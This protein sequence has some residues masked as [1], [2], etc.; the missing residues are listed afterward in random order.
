M[1]LPQLLGLKLSRFCSLRWAVNKR[2]VPAKHHQRQVGL[3]QAE[4][5][6]MGP[7]QNIGTGMH[8]SSHA[9]GLTLAHGCMQT[10]VSH[11]RVSILLR[12]HVCCYADCAGAT[13]AIAA[14][15]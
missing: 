4:V 14:A 7:Q 13:Y 1:P 9:G 5:S 2:Y 6:T 15:V 3:A 10:L 8:V 11:Q 12:M